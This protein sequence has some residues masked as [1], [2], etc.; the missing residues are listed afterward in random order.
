MGRGG[1]YH[2]LMAAQAQDGGGRSAS[3]L[4]PWVE[5]EPD[6][7]PEAI[8]DA[9]YVKPAASAA[10]PETADSIVRAEGMGWPR[11]IRVLLGMVAGYRVR[12]VITFL[13]GVARVVALIGVGVVSAL[14]VR[15]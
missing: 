7:I 9:I 4:A 11:L 15:A 8:P 6:A 14:I 12:L 2:R 3:P 5:P 13:L 1:A 10:L